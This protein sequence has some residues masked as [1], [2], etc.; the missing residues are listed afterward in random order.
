MGIGLMFCGRSPLHEEIRAVGTG[1]AY[2]VL[3]VYRGFEE[4]KWVWSILLLCAS[5]CTRAVHNK[6]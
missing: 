6:K 3:A 4:L 2:T 1:M 5:E